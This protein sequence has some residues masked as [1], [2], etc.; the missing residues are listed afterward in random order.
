MIDSLTSVRSHVS[1][2]MKVNNVRILVHQTF[3]KLLM[4][5]IHVLS[6]V[7]VKLH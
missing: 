3:T 6:H 5:R 2:F 7:M 1:I 4:V